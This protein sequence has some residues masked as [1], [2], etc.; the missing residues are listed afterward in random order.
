MNKKELSWGSHFFFFFFGG[1]QPCSPAVDGVLSWFPS[2]ATKIWT[3]MI[4]KSREPGV[5][6]DVISTVLHN[7]THTLVSHMEKYVYSKLE[8]RGHR[9][10]GLGG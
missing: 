5:R 10:R 3:C 4:V 6:M 2:E 1:R 9:G 8:G 7:R